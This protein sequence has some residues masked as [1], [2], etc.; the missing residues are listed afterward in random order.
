MDSRRA[1]RAD[2]HRPHRARPPRSHPHPKPRSD[3]PQHRHHADRLRRRR[4]RPGTAV[5]D[6]AAVDD[7]ETTAG[8]DTATSHQQPQTTTL[9]TP[10]P[11]DHIWIH[12]LGTP[13]VTPL[14]GAPC[15]KGREAACTEL[16]ALLV[17][18]PGIKNYDLDAM[19]WPRDPADKT[20]KAKSTRR[21]TNFRRLRSWLG[22]TSTGD[23]AFPK[24]GDHTG[25]TGYRLAPEVRTDWDQWRTHATTDP[26]TADTTHLEA[27]AALVTGQP[28]GNT[29]ATRYGW[30]EHLQ[31]DMISEVADTLEELAARRIENHDTTTAHQVAMRG[32][33][34]DSSREGLWR[35]AI[36]STYSRDPA[37]TQQL[38]TDM[39]AHFDDLEVDELEPETNELLRH[40]ARY[41]DDAGRTLYRVGLAS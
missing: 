34:V 10:S 28:F 32:L 18:H 25:Q 15:E 36:M 8:T 27:A 19:L 17:T 3:R 11:A 21:Q 33:T 24:H 4:R 31:Q 7:G 20:A 37:T 12:L 9:D 16:A 40:L 5:D 22:E 13:T 39:L 6:A 1:R 38:I 23:L 26:T 30:A 14:S 29:P 2:P 41:Q 35:L